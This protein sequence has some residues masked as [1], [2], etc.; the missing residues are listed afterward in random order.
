MRAV[1]LVWARTEY[2]GSCIVMAFE[3]KEDAAEFQD[4]CAKYHAKKPQAPHVGGYKDDDP[5]FD[6]WLRR[7]ERWRKRHPAGQHNASADEFT[8]GTLDVCGPMRR[9]TSRKPAPQLHDTK[10]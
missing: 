6:A 1:H 4:R 10:D 7:D 5:A 2:E 9:R 8:V 3:R